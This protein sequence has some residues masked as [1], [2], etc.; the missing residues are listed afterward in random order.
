[1]R[2]LLATTAF[3]FVS[4]CGGPSAPDVPPEAKDAAAAL[5]AH[6]AVAGGALKLKG[7]G[8]G[9]KDKT[10]AKAL[11]AAEAKED[12]SEAIKLW[13]EGM[14]DQSCRGFAEGLGATVKE[15]DAEGWACIVPADDA[16]NPDCFWIAPGRTG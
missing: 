8:A 1:M 11:V 7:G 10:E 13:A 4:A 16:A 9:C 3:A 12:P 5:D 2:I 14:Q 6:A 15:T